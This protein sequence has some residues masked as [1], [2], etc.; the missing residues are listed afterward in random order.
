ME[1]LAG[2]WSLASRLTWQNLLQLMALNLVWFVCC[3]PIVTI[4]PATLAAYWFAARVLRDE[5]APFSL[6]AYLKALGHYLVPGLVWFLAWV[7]VLFTAYSNLAFWPH[8]LP[9]FMTV[10]LTILVVYVVWFLAAANA[11]YLEGLVVTGLRPLAALKNALWT[12]AANPLYS[13]LL[14]FPLVFALTL[15]IALRTVF[16]VILA[17]VVLLFAAVCAQQVPVRPREA[18]AP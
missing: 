17:A 13:N 14:P 5:D 2:A 11:Y 4:G 9:G 3:L 18:P 10:A 7:V 6:G 16:F 1:A 8:L 12:T 15:S